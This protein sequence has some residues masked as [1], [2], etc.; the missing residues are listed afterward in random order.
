VSFQ[1]SKTSLSTLQSLGL[2]ICNNGDDKSDDDDVVVVDGD[3]DD[4][5][6]TVVGCIWFR[7]ISITCFLRYNT[8]L[9]IPV[10]VVDHC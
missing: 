9:Y 1:A 6:V 7:N 5:D 10:V 3:D 4:D 8:V 2:Y